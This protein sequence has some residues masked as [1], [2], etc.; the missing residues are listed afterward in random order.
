MKNVDHYNFMHRRLNGNK[1]VDCFNIKHERLNRNSLIIPLFLS[2][3]DFFLF[4][5][6]WM[7]IKYNKKF[8]LYQFQT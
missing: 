6:Q 4:F 2:Y 1:Y 5:K 3:L 7:N 8:G